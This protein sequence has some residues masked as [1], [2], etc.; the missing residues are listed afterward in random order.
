MN[1]AKKNLRVGK[2]VAKNL[3]LAILLLSIAV[4]V[5]VLERKRFNCTFEKVKC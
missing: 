5:K 2:A 4:I 1:T 3:D